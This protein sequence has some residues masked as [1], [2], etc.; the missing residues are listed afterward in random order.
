V[1][2]TEKLVEKID[3]LMGEADSLVPVLQGFRNV[4]HFSWAET[5]GLVRHLLEK[6]RELLSEGSVKD[7][8]RLLSE[9]LVY[10]SRQF[11]VV[12]RDMLSVGLDSS[13]PDVFNRMKRIREGFSELDDLAFGGGG[14][15]AG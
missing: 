15:C 5:A 1:R 11:D 6:P 10:L 4:Q 12:L 14:V 9:Q 2:G 3:W 7:G 13:H 8:C